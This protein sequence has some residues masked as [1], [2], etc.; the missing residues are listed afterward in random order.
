MVTSLINTSNRV[1]NLSSTVSTY[2]RNAVFL[3]NVLMLSEGRPGIDDKYIL[4]DG[5]A[6][7]LVECFV[8]LTSLGRLRLD[9]AK[10]TYE[11]TGLLGKPIRDIGRLHL[12]TRYCRIRLYGYADYIR[13]MKTGQPLSLISDHHQCCMGRK[14]LNA[15]CGHSR[16]FSTVLWPGSSTTWSNPRKACRNPGIKTMK[17]KMRNWLRSSVVSP[18]IAQHHPFNYTVSPTRSDTEAILT[19]WLD[20]VDATTTNADLEDWALDTYEWLGLVSMQSPRVQASD[21]IDPYLSRYQIPAHADKAA[22]PCNMVKVS[23]KGFIPSSWTRDLFIILKYN[24][25]LRLQTENYAR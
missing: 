9:L 11:R 2:L 16:M 20:I 6:F 7:L 13:L 25:D 12:K 19:P 10:E 14:G 4:Q 23:W 1:G 8:P 21:V 5:K 22:T 24:Q 18:P 3:G 15:S 17:Q